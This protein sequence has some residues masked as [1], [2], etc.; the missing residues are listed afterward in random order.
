M[1]SPGFLVFGYHGNESF[2]DTW[3]YCQVLFIMSGP[4]RIVKE[5]NAQFFL[6]VHKNTIVALK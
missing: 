2:H 1:S 3:M 5:I 4:I 6:C